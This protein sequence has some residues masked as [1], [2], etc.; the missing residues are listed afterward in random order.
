MYSQ[1][2]P[3][4]R[5]QDARRQVHNPQRLEARHPRVGYGQHEGYHLGQHYQH[6][7]RK[8]LRPVDQGGLEHGDVQSAFAHYGLCFSLGAEDW[9]GRSAAGPDAAQVDEPA[10][11]RFLRCCDEVG[12]VLAVAAQCSL[13]VEI[14]FPRHMNDGRH[15]LHCRAQRGQVVHTGRDCAEGDACG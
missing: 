15:V 4:Q 6:V 9:V 5:S 13:A 2:V 8:I 14:F 7:G 12:C 3:F 10:R 11:A 1:I